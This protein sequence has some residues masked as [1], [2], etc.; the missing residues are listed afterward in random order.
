M[1]ILNVTPDSFY[2]G[3]RYLSEAEILAQAEKMLEEGADFVDVGGYS[4][5]PR[6]ED[7]PVAEEI[8]RSIPAISAIAKNFPGTIISVDTFRSEVAKAAVEAGACMVNDIAGGTLDAQMFETVSR[9]KVPYIVMHMR[10][11]PQTMSGQTQYVNVVKEIIDYFHEKIN[12]L[13]SFGVRYMIVDP[14]FGFSKTTAQNFNV[15][16]NLEKFSILGKPLMVGLS[17]KSMVWKTLEVKA[18]DALNGTTALNMVALL[19]GAGI[20]RVHD[21]KQARE[22]IKLFTSLQTNVAI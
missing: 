20:L 19:K 12:A 22:G 15:L 17:R 14:G 10:G 3:G 13:R 11:N 5:R 4:S 1:G 6:A 21:V 16:Q 18:A 2:D 9:L 8:Q 7:I